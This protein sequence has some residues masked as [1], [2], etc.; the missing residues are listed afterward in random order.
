[1]YSHRKLITL[2]TVAALAAVVFFST[3]ADFLPCG[4]ALHRAVGWVGLAAEPERIGPLWGWLVRWCNCRATPMGRVSAMFG[5]VNAVLVAYIG[6][7]LF[8]VAIAY[9]RTKHTTGHSSSRFLWIAE[10][11]GALFGVAFIVTPGFWV[12]ATRLNGLMVALVF[13]LAA[14]ALLAHIIVHGIHRHT[15]KM[16]VASGALAAIGCW[17]GSVGLVFLP[18]LGVLIWVIKKCHRRGMWQLSRIWLWG[19][20]VAFFVLPGLVYQSLAGSTDVMVDLIRAV[21]RELLLTGLVAFLVIG[22]IPFAALFHL[23]WTKRFYNPRQCVALLGGWLFV[24]CVVAG[25]TASSG[26]L[27]FGRTTAAFVDDVLA[28]LNGRTWLVSEGPLDDLFLLKKPSDV[29]LVTLARNREAAYG[30]ILVDWA[31]SDLGASEDLLFAAELGPQ[32][33]LD[34]WHKADSN[35][36]QKVLIPAEYFATRETWRDVWEKHKDGLA[37]KSEP[38]QQYIHRLLGKIGVGFGCRLLSEGRKQD[39]WN[40]FYF[41]VNDVDRDNLSAL[42]NL[43]EVIKGGLAMSPAIKEIIEARLRSAQERYTHERAKRV[44]ASSGRVYVD[45]DMRRRYEELLKAAEPEP[46]A[47]RLVNAVKRAGKNKDSTL[48]A[49]DE[50]RKAVDD[51]AVEIGSVSRILVSLDMALGDKKSAENDAL[52]ALRHNRQD[53]AANALMGAL[54]GEAGD[55]ASAERFLRR[56]VRGGNVPPTAYNDLAE[57]LIRTGKPEE[58]VSFAQKAV[59]AQPANWCFSETLASAQLAA[60]Q[61]DAAEK[62]LATAMQC[63]D[64]AKVQPEARNTLELTRARLWKAQG[65]VAELRPLVQSLKK[66]GNLRPDQQRVLAW[67]EKGF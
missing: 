40:L 28:E 67:L 26:A 27:S 39:A 33:F 34:E 1:M 43:S 11:A 9:A 60:R 13:P 2:I 57:T 30:R 29:R 63:A 51:G 49:R 5:M 64:D 52:D 56:A 65:K 53:G 3:I 14:L 45:D 41:V 23:V 38:H 55:Y 59:A 16:L 17:E 61:L 37:E 54:R 25:Y 35:F 42:V 50:L 6:W 19:F 10:G 31:N 15:V 24:V 12:A 18:P 32:S 47:V 36:T 21:P 44:L 4:D 7:C 22:F 62:A 66:R 46:R 20:D 8:P 48:R 58:A